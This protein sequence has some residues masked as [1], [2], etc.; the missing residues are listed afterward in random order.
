MQSESRAGF[1]KFLHSPIAVY[2]CQK[3]TN[4]VKHMILYND[5]HQ[6]DSWQRS[7]HYTASLLAH[8]RATV[9]Q[10]SRITSVELH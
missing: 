6:I 5:M 2:D 8:V 3:N 4:A 10:R 1:I 7:V 9:V